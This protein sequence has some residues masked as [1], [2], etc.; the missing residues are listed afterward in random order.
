MSGS[1]LRY[2][3]NIAGWY[4]R[5]FSRAQDLAENRV[6]ANLLRRLGYWSQP[7]AS[8]LDLGCGTGLFLDLMHRSGGRLRP[9]L[10][11]GFDLSAS[12]LE[13]AIRKHPEY[14]HSFMQ[15]D[16]L[17][18]PPFGPFTHILSLFAAYYVDRRLL[19]QRIKMLASGGGT[20]F[21][22]LP[23]R[24]TTGRSTVTWGLDKRNDVETYWYTPQLVRALYG[25]SVEVPGLSY[26]AKHL[27]RAIGTGL[28]F[29][30]IG[31]LW[32]AGGDYLVVWGRL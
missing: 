22:T 19:A 8:I 32:P 4:D 5:M 1:G 26:V 2:Y 28:E 12:M 7:G 20:F 14:L 10:Y 16:M 27:P 18:P 17:G 15:E 13:V 11:T 29:Q 31:R 25:R 6:L 9:D 3:D 24:R 21:L 23:T 30:T